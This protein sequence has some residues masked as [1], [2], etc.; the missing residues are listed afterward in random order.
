MKLN[1]EINYIPAQEVLNEVRNELKT[2]FERGLVDDSL[3]YPV[4]RSCI[5]KMGLRVFPT[6]QVII[7]I[8]DYKGCLPNDFHKLMLAIGCFDYKV[9]SQNTENPQLYE[10]YEEINKAVLK[11]SEIC[12]DQCGDNWNIIQK[13]DTFTTS[14][15]EFYPLQVSA[16]SKPWCA[17]GCLNYQGAQNQIDICGSTL[18]ANF[19]SGYIYLEYI[20]SLESDED[21]LIPDF[22]PIRDWIIALCKLKCLGSVYY[23]GEDSIRNKYMDLK[24]EVSP[25]ETNAKSFVS[26][27]GYKELYDMRKLFAGRYRKFSHQ[28]YGA[29]G[30]DYTRT[31]SW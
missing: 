18:T 3:M 9:V 12:V 10:T 17:N 25:L 28:I 11:P 23:N 6:D 30:R 8:Q 24:A 20:Q 7:P 31:T 1:K 19:P 13:F 27:S 29:H 26:R 22:A 5:S 21:L 2:Y 4:I 16:S 14:W 15:R